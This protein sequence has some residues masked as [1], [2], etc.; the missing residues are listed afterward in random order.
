ME[1]S[2]LQSDGGIDARTPN[3]FIRGFIKGAAGLLNLF[4]AKHSHSGTPEDDALELL[5]DVEEVAQDFYA[6]LPHIETTAIK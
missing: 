6:V 5:A 1:C 2:T 4:P 3:A